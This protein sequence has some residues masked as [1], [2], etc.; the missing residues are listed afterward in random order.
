MGSNVLNAA[1]VGRQGELAVLSAA[2]RAVA[3]GRGG[4]VLV[5]GEPGIGKSALVGRGLSGIPA[6]CRRLT[7]VADE[8]TERFPMLVLT[9]ALGASAGPDAS[10]AAP[11][12]MGDPVLAA[13]E[14]VLSRVDELCA[15]GP[16]VLVAE[17]LQWAD[18][19]SLLAV[20][21]LVRAARQQPL[22]LVGTCRPVP[23]RPELRQLRQTVAA[24]GAVLDLG[25]LSEAESVALVEQLL[26]AP[27]GPRLGRLAADASGNPLYLRETLDAI[28]R[29]GG[30]AVVDDVADLTGPPR[31]AVS[32]AGAISDRLAFLSADSAQ[33]L[34]AA[35]LLA[36]EFA[37][38]DL[39]AVTGR[40]ASELVPAI[41]EAIAAGV[42]TP[43]EDRLRF[44]H[45]LVR[46]GLYGSV[47]AALRA[48][49]HRDAAEAL[50]TAGL[51]PERVAA[52]LLLSPPEADAWATA[53][54]ADHG[55]VLVQHARAIAEELLT[56]MLERPLPDESRRDD[57]E[58]ALAT[59]AFRSSSTELLERAAGSVLARGNGADLRCRAG[60][61]LAYT[62][63]RT[64]RFDQGFE[65]LGSLIADMS[66]SE[67]WRARLRALEALVAIAS[68]DMERAARVAEEAQRSGRRH[69]DR[70]AEGYALHVLSMTAMLRNDTT[71]GLERVDKALDAV[72]ADP[73]LVDLQALLLLN[74]LNWSADVDLPDQAE[75]ALRSVRA[76]ADQ[77]DRSRAMTLGLDAARFYYRVGR[78]DDALAELETAD[79]PPDDAFG[80]MV[81]HSLKA[82]IAVHRDEPDQATAELAA[83]SDAW[84]DSA[85]ARNNS[86]HLLLA[87][88]AMAERSGEPGDALTVLRP[89]VDEQ[90]M[91][92]VGDRYDWMPS[93]VRLA[94]A[95]GEP[96]LAARA[97]EVAAAEAEQEPGHGGRSAAARWCAALLVGDVTVLDDCAERYRNVGRLPA[98]GA[99]MEDAAAAAAE[100]GDMTGA[101]WRLVE[102]VETYLKLSADWDVN[103]ADA[104]LRS[105]GVR[106]GQRSRLRRPV[107]GWAALTPTETRVAQLV[108]LG[109]SNPEVAA[110][111]FLS[112]RTVQTHVTHILAKLEIDSRHG[113]AAFVPAG[114]EVQPAMP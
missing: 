54:L 43:V 62:L 56:R 18:G 58:L 90:D 45:A 17:D 69:A 12:A 36:A 46:D 95:A 109:Q 16:V 60:W 92:Y 68:G 64:G 40:N 113:I 99:V 30:I 2:L 10:G 57:L 33:V 29:D 107:S 5:A 41:D 31:P 86:G 63:L 102:A 7:A 108:A 103:R 105:L 44:R 55:D 67:A 4:A 112:R 23:P 96:R 6:G 32:L 1:W 79:I 75:D 91:M 13:V 89:M 15:E 65:V 50:A 47:P 3:A 70:A 100:A 73:D 66:V 87:R 27:T 101:R 61:I 8:M 11:W 38:T 9:D 35:T 25:P 98:L 82:L 37:M 22:L 26:K 42:L 59:A 21:R 19:A 53:W 39:V 71:L 111:L 77:V 72:A 28:S 14:R 74:R 88:A 49:L 85:V 24:G 110:Q 83:A 81:S 76:L 80:A 34:R 94:L 97:A 48:A 51:P 114:H 93:A 106:R 84:T 104:R 78:W 52:Q 20:S